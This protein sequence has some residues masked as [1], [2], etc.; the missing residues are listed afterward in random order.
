MQSRKVFG[1]AAMVG[2]SNDGKRMGKPA[3][4]TEN[5]LAVSPEG[6]AN[7][8]TWMAPVVSMH[9]VE[10]FFF[11]ELILAPEYL[12]IYVPDCRNFQLLNIFQFS[13][14]KNVSWYMQIPVS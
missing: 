5:F 14:S 12:T 6:D 8:G 2:I 11:N 7:V 10:A 13:I 3:E 4:E 1:T 9:F